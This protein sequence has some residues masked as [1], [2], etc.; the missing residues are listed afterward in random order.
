MRDSKFWRVVAV[1]MC[2]GI[3]YVGHGL[4]DPYGDGATSLIGKAHAGGITVSPAPGS[5]GMQIY[6]TDESG[7]LLHVWTNP[8]TGAPRYVGTAHP[9]GTFS[10]KPL[11]GPPAK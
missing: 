8:N 6:T 11:G 5:S 9:N 1:F 2:V 7:T 10:S 3:F 4:H